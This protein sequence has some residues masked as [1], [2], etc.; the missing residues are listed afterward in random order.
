MSQIGPGE[1]IVWDLDGK[2][3]LRAGPMPD[4][5]SHTGSQPAEWGIT[6]CI[7]RGA[8][9]AERLAFKPPPGS[10]G[11]DASLIT[12][13]SDGIVWIFDHTDIAGTHH[14][15]P[16]GLVVCHVCGGDRVVLDEYSHRHTCGYCNGSGRIHPD[17]RLGP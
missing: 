8:A 1:P 3:I 14:Y 13:E 17:R 12:I 16:D 5:A 2:P 15:V 4:Y 10:P 11:I 6:D 9:H 7:D